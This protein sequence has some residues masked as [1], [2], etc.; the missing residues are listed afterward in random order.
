MIAALKNNNEVYRL[1]PKDEEVDRGIYTAQRSDGQRV[2][3][4]DYQLRFFDVNNEI[5]DLDQEYDMYEDERINEKMDQKKLAVDGNNSLQELFNNCYMNKD[6]LEARVCT[7][8]QHDALKKSNVSF[9]GERTGD[10]QYLVA[11]PRAELQ[12]VQELNL[13]PVHNHQLGNAKV[14]DIQNHAKSQNTVTTTLTINNNELDLLQGADF[15]FYA[16]TSYFNDKQISVHLSDSDVGKFLK[17]FLSK[18]DAFKEMESRKLATI[19][20]T[21][22]SIKDMVKAANINHIDTGELGLGVVLKAADLKEVSKIFAQNGMKEHYHPKT[23]PQ[24]LK[25]SMSMKK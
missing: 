21:T 3:L 8:Q 23:E 1:S 16:E 25:M 12:Q 18:N 9:Y 5:E 4:E 19:D 6:I 13:Y 11:I 20:L 10:N 24:Q 2:Q 7:I 22:D 14:E 17:K 15:K